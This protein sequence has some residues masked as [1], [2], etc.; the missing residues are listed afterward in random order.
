MTQQL[1]SWIASVPD[2]AVFNFGQNACYRIEGTLEFR[3]RKGLAFEGNG[4]TFR[5]FNAPA[6]QRAI[7]RVVGSTGITFHNMT[8]DGSYAAGGTFNA[9]LQHAHAI[10]LRGTNATVANVNMSDVAGDCVYL[11]LGYDGVTRSSGSVHDSTCVRTGRNAVSVTAGDNILVQHVT[12]GAIGFTAF[13]VEPN[14]LSG[15]GSKGVTFDSNTIGSYYLYAY[16][17][18]SNAPISNQTFSNNTVTGRGLRIGV[19]NPSSTTLRPQGVT[20]TGN[21]SNTSQWSPAMEFHN[22]DTLS[23]TGNTVPIGGGALATVE[24]SCYVNVSGN[25]IPGGTQQD[26]ITNSPTTC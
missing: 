24:S 5:S 7:W 18:V 19:V 21:S 8:I 14:T 22:V 1:L 17:I 11:G 23:V 2:N 12:T 16:A 4:S 3:G 10:D 25:S 9:S 20:I 6:D 26:T 13:D 15:F